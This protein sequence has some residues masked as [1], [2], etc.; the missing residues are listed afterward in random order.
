MNWDHV[1]GNWNQMTGKVKEKWGNPTDD[2]LTVIAGNRDQLADMLQKRYGHA[3]EQAEKELHEFMK[4][5]KP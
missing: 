3:T 1:Q 4:G 2:D 5:L